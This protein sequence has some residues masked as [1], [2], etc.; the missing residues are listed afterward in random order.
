[1][2]KVSLRAKGT[3]ES[4]TPARSGKPEVFARVFTDDGVFPNSSLP[5]LLYRKAMVLP[6]RDP[7]AAFETVFGAHGWEG[8]W[9]NGIFPYHHYHSTAHEVLGVYRGTARVQLGG[10]D[11]IAVEVHPADVLILPAGVAH[12]NLD[13]S[14]D[15]GVVGA[16][17]AGQDW[18]VNYGRA[19]ERPRADERIGRVDLPKEDPV[20]G[21]EGPLTEYWAGS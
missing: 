12:K 3:T 11:G 18:D 5:L 17:P 21:A 9:R 8:S 1:M 7:A 4:V 14:D 16:Y 13:S 10:E 20:F 19:G 15:F 6:E 2:S